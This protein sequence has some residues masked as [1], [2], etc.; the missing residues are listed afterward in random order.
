M[1]MGFLRGSANMP[2]C[3]TNVP[4][5]SMLGLA[6]TISLLWVSTTLHK[7]IDAV[8]DQIYIIGW[9]PEARH[10]FRHRPDG[11]RQDHLMM[12]A[13]GHGSAIIDGQRVALKKG[14][15]L[16]IPRGV[17]HTYWADDEDPW[18]I[19]WVHFLGE[20]ADYYVDRIPRKGHPVPIEPDSQQEA[21]RLFR[22]CLDALYEGYGLTS[23]IYA[24][25]SVQHILSLLLYRNHALPME[26]RKKNWRTGQEPIFDY[27]RN[28]LDQSLRLEDLAAEA[29]L[30]LS[31]W[32]SKLIREKTRDE[33]PESV[34]AMAG[35]WP[36]LQTTEE[37]R[38]GGD[39]DLVRETL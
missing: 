14:E 5:F 26:P 13:N 6:V 24:A 17:E 21:S 30:S 33:W 9:F 15:L 12:C 11:A 1:E 36:D 39:A 8:A 34:K 32:I 31:K 37:I 7:K 10:H 4:M 28:N 22:Y 25:Q 29:G 38:S 35:A 2:N 23:L 20:D 18:S 27:M 16:I 19:F 3:S